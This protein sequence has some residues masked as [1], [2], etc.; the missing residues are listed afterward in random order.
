MRTDG[1]PR[2]EFRLGRVPRACVAH[3]E[4]LQG[5]SKAAGVR[6]RVGPMP[7]SVRLA[8]QF[9]GVIDVTESREYVR[10]QRWTKPVLRAFP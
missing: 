6:R 9:G 10:H 2:R 3:G 4:M 5:Q 1:G 7:G 8:W